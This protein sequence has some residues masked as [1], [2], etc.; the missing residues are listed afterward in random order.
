MGKG[1]R[2]AMAEGER[3]ER[4]EGEVPQNF[5][6]ERPQMADGENA[7]D[8]GMPDPRGEKN[9]D[10]VIQKGVNLFGGVTE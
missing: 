9:S 1:G 4:P 3:T 7:F 10:F 5:D 8:K 2:P 6:S